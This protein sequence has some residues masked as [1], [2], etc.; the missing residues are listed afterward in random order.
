VFTFHHWKA[1]G[2]AAICLALKRSGF[3][4]QEYYVVHSENPI[5]VHIANMNALTHD[6]IL[7]LANG[8]EAKTSDWRQPLRI[9]AESSAAFCGDCAEGV[10]WILNS[11]LGDEA[12]LEWWTDRLGAQ[13]GPDNRRPPNDGD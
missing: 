9:N 2:W 4:L 8:T 7:V 13:A 1:A 11:S 5:S 10:G 6:A 3:H 12:V